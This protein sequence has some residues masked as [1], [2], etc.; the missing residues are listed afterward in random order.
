MKKIQVF[1]KTKTFC[2]QCKAVKRWLDQRGC[3]YELYAIEEHPDIV[4]EAKASGAVAAPLTIVDGK[5][6]ISGFNDDALAL[7]IGGEKI[8]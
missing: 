8:K 5:T 4:E 2:P 7:Y 3:E 1:E 6:L